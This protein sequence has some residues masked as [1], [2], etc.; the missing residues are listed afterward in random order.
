MES[1]FPDTALGWVKHSTW[2]GPV[3]VPWDRVDDDDIGSWAAAHQE[4][5]VDRFAAEI[6]RGGRHTE[7]SILV[8]QAN[9]PDGREK[10]IDGHHRA[11]A[12]HFKLG[13]PVLAYVGTVPARWMQQ[14][15]ETHSSQLHSG[16]DPANKGNTGR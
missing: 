16:G 14:A 4:D 6:A 2:A 3:H 9:H 11:L 13:K 12:R 10:I 8:H 7:P 5:A 1:N 15:M